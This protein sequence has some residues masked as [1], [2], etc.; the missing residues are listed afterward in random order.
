MFATTLYL[1]FICSGMIPAHNTV[2]ILQYLPLQVLLP[3]MAESQTLVHNLT[4]ACLQSKL[5]ATRGP[6]EA[7]LLKPRSPFRL[8]ASLLSFWSKRQGQQE[9]YYSLYG[10]CLGVHS[11]CCLVLQE[12]VVLQRRGPYMVITARDWRLLAER[13]RER[14]M[15]G[16]KTWKKKWVLSIKHW[17]NDRI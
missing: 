1:L 16:E 15:E 13:E 4:T 3:D 17:L 9:T 6:Y 7:W 2:C 12:R 8:S 5:N 11:S 14:E 10:L